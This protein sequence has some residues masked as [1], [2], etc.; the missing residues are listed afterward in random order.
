MMAFELPEGNHL[1]ERMLAPVSLGWVSGFRIFVTSL[2]EQV[3]FNF[4][5]LVKDTKL[6]IRQLSL[7]V[8]GR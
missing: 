8:I 3:A 2:A 6:I 7:F 1:E 5:G 4:V